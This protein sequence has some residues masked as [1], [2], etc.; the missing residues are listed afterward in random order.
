MS[1]HAPARGPQIDDRRY[2][3]GQS[4]GCRLDAS[5]PAPSRQLAPTGRKALMATS[6]DDLDLK[7]R[8]DALLTAGAE[9]ELRLLKA[10][11]KAEKRLAEAMAMLASNEARLLRA[12]QRLERSRESVAEAEAA[13]REVRERRAAGP[14][15]DQD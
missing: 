9:A 1:C 6:A 13:L 7:H 2:H 3:A 4:S 15:R 12:Q 14:T 11:R 8:M 10:E 5:A